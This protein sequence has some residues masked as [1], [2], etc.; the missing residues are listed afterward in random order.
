MIRVRYVRPPEKAS[1]VAELRARG[2]SCR[3]FGDYAEC[4][5][6]VNEVEVY[7]VLVEVGL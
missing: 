4:T 3:D 6:P 7:R 1:A 2:F 5:K